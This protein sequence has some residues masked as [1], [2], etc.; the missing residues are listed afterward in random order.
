MNAVMKRAMVIFA[1]FL[2]GCGWDFRPV[3]EGYRGVFEYKP[4]AGLSQTVTATIEGDL[5]AIS[6]S[7]NSTTSPS[8]GFRLGSF[9]IS[10]AIGNRYNMI[11]GAS[12]YV[13]YS[14]TE[15]IGYFNSGEKDIFYPGVDDSRQDYFIRRGSSVVVEPEDR[16][17]RH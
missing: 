11:D 9:H 7:D 4:E 16:I 10:S 1:V 13:L 5:V 2:S 6:R 15:R 3:E 17:I 14:G 8:G 12:I